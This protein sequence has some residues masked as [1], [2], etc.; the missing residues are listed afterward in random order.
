MRC[1]Q[2]AALPAR[3]SRP[4]CSSPRSGTRRTFLIF[5]FAIAVVAVSGLRPL[6]RW[7]LAPAAI[8]LL[9]ALPVGT[10]KAQ[11]DEGRVIYETDTEYQ[12]AR[13]IERDD[14]SRALELNE[15]QAQHSI[16]DPDTV[17]TDD[18]WDGH[19]VL[20][21]TALAEPPQ[22]RGDPGQRGGHDLARLRGVLPVHAGG[23]RGDRLGAVG[24][25]PALLRDGQPAAAAVP[26]GRAS[27]PS[28][29]RRA[30]RRDLGRRLPPALHPVLPGH[31]RVLRALPR[32]AGAWRRSDRE[33]RATR[34]ARTTWRRC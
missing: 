3:C 17:L 7:A 28:P 30:L 15:G 20:P 23:R 26:R 21:F 8:A 11:T 33:R 18:V 6:G 34:R 12:Y 10:L 19:L 4:C 25:R 13:V 9:A 29:H 32:P 16:Y 5:A 22:P 31:A 24:D 2:P 1:P 27:V 14:G